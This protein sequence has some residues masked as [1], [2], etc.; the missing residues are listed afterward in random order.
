[1]GAASTPGS[2]VEA[3]PKD[4]IEA[5]FLPLIGQLGL[6][7]LQQGFLRGRW[8]DQVRW[9]E[10]KAESTQRWYRWL[11]LITITG[12]VVIP[13]LVGLNVTGTASE[14]IRWTVFGLGLVVALAAAIEGFFHYGERWPHYRHLAELLKSEGWQFFQLSGQ[15]AG[16]AGHAD[17]YPLFA[18]HVEAIVQHDVEV[19]FTAVVAG[20][21]QPQEGGQGEQG[22]APA[23]P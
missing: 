17:V 12:G 2:G 7:P 3:A 5:Q 9:A 21:T 15:Y 14:G 1:M 22:Q 4:W 13:A 23:G 18:A 11:R 19:F 16:A 20:Q 6:P 10:G 8:L